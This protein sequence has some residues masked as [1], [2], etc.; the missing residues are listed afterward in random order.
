MK[1]VN[2]DRTFGMGFNPGGGAYIEFIAECVI[3]YKVLGGRRAKK[4][5]KRRVCNK[6]GGPMDDGPNPEINSDHV[7]YLHEMCDAPVTDAERAEYTT[8]LKNK[9]NEEQDLHAKWR[10]EKE[11]HDA[12]LRG[13]NAD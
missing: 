1:F 2:N 5:S 11:D 8:F 4:I 6:Y 10:R 9:R 3:D 7:K 13:G 12:W